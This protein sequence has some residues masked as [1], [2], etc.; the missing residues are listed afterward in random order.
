MED[1]LQNCIVP[2]SLCMRPCICEYCYKPVKH[3]VLIEY[4]FGILACDEHHE[5][6]LRDCKAYMHENGI[7][8][9]NDARTIAGI[10]ECLSYVKEMD[11]RIPVRRT[12]GA[13]EYTWRMIDDWH[14]YSTLVCV[15]GKWS[16]HLRNDQF[17]KHVPLTEFLRDDIAPSFPEGF[18]QSIDRAIRVLEEG[19]YRN[20]HAKQ[21]LCSA[22][23]HEVSEHPL[24]GMAVMP[25]GTIV[26]CFNL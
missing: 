4:L 24:V 23:T 6:A 12:S 5:W 2:H 22:H 9:L 15:E 25:N 7:V 14:E 26:R 19:V 3:H 11:G 20:E 13:M 18:P 16:I 17:R 10:S 21:K 8:R 1:P